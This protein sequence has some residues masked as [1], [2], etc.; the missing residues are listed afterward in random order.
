M[1]PRRNIKPGVRMTVWP[2]WASGFKAK[3]SATVIRTPFGNVTVAKFF[4]GKQLLASLG[5]CCLA[6]WYFLAT[7]ETRKVIGVEVPHAVLDVTLGKLLDDVG[8]DTSTRLPAAT[9]AV[10]KA[11]GDTVWELLGVHEPTEEELL[12][13]RDND[14]EGRR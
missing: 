2:D 12:H 13:D 1:A 10:L 3:I 4:S 5:S 14:D 11:R 7:G 8:C 9:E 6:L